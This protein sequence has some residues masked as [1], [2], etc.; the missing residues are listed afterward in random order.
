MFFDEKN[1]PYGK[2]N[3]IKVFHKT[4]N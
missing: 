4:Y 3:Y 1:P 2:K